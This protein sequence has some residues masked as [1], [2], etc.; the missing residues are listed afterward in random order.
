[1]NNISLRLAD[2]EN[3]IDLYN[4]YLKSLSVMKALDNNT[5]LPY[6]KVFVVDDDFELGNIKKNKLKHADFDL[7]ENKKI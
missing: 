3:D 5:A 4:R 1:M 2:F 7:I 6:S